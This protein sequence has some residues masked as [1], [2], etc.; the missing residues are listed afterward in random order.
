MSCWAITSTYSNSS[1][2]CQCWQAHWVPSWPAIHPNHPHCKTCAS[3]APRTQTS[4]STLP[5]HIS[6]MLAVPRSSRAS[7]LAV[8]QTQPAR[9]QTTRSAVAATAP[10]L[11]STL[12]SIACF[13]CDNGPNMRYLRIRI[14]YAVSL[15]H[16]HTNHITHERRSIDRLNSD[17]S[18]N[19]LDIL[20]WN[21][22]TNYSH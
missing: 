13:Q 22:S 17:S 10:T 12:L 11:P 7:S 19:D 15:T 3:T 16:T 4:Q 14:T 1:R 9:S 21:H 6:L 2:V 18:L 5:I 20:H 8:S